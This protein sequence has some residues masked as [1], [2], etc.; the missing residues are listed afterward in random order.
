LNDLH[1]IIDANTNRASEGMRVL[2]DL[3]RFSLDNESLSRSLKELRHQLQSGI[4]SLGIPQSTL[5]R[6]RDSA[7]DVGTEISTPNEGGREQGVVDIAAAAAKRS[8]EAMRVLEESA[9]ALGHAGSVFESIRYSLYD[10]HRDLTLNLERPNPKWSVCVLLTKSL[11]LHHSP[12]TVIIQAA[13]AGAGCIQVREK[14]MP[15]DELLTHT[16]LMVSCAHEHGLAVIVNDRVDVALA[17]QADGVHL[18]QHDL[19]ISVARSI[20]GTRSLI[21]RSC[22]TTEHLHEAFK[23]GADYCGLGPVFPSTTK[24]KSNL[25][26][27]A[28]L[29][30]AMKDQKLRS[31]PMLAISG[32]TPENLEQI[33]SIGFPGVAVSSAVCSAEDP[34]SACISM[35]ES[36]QQHSGCVEC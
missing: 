34:Y 31:K 18:G 10:I 4:Q 21:G 30:D 32:I 36:M 5:L 35:V 16:S 23:Q 27:V 14:D 26:G 7:S 20:L 12:E 1:R 29:Q 33:A 15:G 9:K 22:S 19:P 17:T 11:C 3:A 28:M 24:H 25:G 2:E 6:S 13:K 8:Q